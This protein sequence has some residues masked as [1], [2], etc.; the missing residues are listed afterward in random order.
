MTEFQINHKFYWADYKKKSKGLRDE[1]QYAVKLISQF[2][3]EG[4]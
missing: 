4:N 1:G 3:E 2:I